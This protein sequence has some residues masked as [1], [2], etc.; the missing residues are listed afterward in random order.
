M[1]YDGLYQ[2]LKPPPDNYYSECDTMAGRWLPQTGAGRV[3]VD[4]KTFSEEQKDQTL[5]SRAESAQ[6]PLQSQEALLKEV[7]LLETTCCY[8]VVG[9]WARIAEKAVL[10]GVF[11]LV[12]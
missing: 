5:S 2:Y 8:S 7:G 9:A 12:V 1:Q 10:D 6:Q 4:A 11:V 3:F